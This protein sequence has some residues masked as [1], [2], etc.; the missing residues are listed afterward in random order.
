MQSFSKLCADHDFAENFNPK[1]GEGC[2][3]PAYT[4][5]SSGFM[6]FQEILRQ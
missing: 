2:Y 1:I 4:W 3:C 5:T 6:I